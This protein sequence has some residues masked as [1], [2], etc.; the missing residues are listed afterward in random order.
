M[1]NV[2]RIFKCS[3]NQ[4]INSGFSLSAFVIVLLW[5]CYLFLIKHMNLIKSCQTKEWFLVESYL[6]SLEWF[7]YATCFIGM[8]ACDGFDVANIYIYIYIKITFVYNLWKSKLHVKWIWRLAY[9]NIYIC[10]CFLYS[11][12]KKKKKKTFMNKVLCSNWGASTTTFK[13]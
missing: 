6:L 12:N 5:L 7:K 11:C 1:P 8:L 9:Q 10:M 3:T 4:N 2:S 13:D